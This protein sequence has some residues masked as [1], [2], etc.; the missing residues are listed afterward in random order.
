MPLAIFFTYTRAAWLSA[1]FGF[2]IVGVFMVKNRKK[3]LAVISIILCL[4]VL[5]GAIFILDDTSRAFAFS[6]MNEEGPVNARLDLYITYMKMF[7]DHPLLGVGFGRFSELSPYYFRHIYGQKPS[8]Y[9]TREMLGDHDTFAGLLAETGLIGIGLV[10]FIYLM[11]FL[12]SI[13]S[14]NGSAMFRPSA[15]DGNA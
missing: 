15:I 6:R 3:E 2:L 8:L 5:L 7:K 14:R 10:L 11:I 9:G 4:T 13:N 1:F 12:A